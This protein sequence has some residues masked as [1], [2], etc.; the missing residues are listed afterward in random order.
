MTPLE[1]EYVRTCT[2]S[3]KRDISTAKSVATYN[4]AVAGCGSVLDLLDK[5]ERGIDMMY[6]T[7]EAELPVLHTDTTR[8]IEVTDND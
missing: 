5:V 6:A 2:Q 1:L 8:T 3:H 4:G 7:L